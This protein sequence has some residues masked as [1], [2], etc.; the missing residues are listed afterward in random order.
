MITAHIKD[1]GGSDRFLN[2][3]DF[4]WLMAGVGWWIDLSRLQSDKAYIDECLQRAL[5]SHSDLLRKRR[6]T[7]GAVRIRIAPLPCRPH[8]SAWHCDGR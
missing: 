3:V 5:T 1:P 2:L 4:Q 7:C 8:S 6:S